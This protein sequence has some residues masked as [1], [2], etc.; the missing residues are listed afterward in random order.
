M[1]Q[2]STSHVTRLLYSA[3]LIGF[4]AGCSSTG[5]DGDSHDG[6]QV[7]GGV[8]L[9]VQEFTLSLSSVQLLVDGEVVYSNSQD[10]TFFMTS[11]FASKHLA[12]GNH[13]MS[14]KVVSQV[15]ASVSYVVSGLVDMT[16]G[17]PG[18]D[19]RSHQWPDRVVS[20]RVGAGVEIP[21]KVP[22]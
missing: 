15:G 9:Q 2:F 12:V 16:R 19:I 20:H 21:L 14:L 17:L 6:W 3:A 10:P 4:G 13:V 5:P 11:G 22:R 7:S 1:R 18:M 8:G